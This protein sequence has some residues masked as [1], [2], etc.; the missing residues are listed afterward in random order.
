MATSYA[1]DL[2]GKVLTQT[3]STT[4]IVAG[5]WYTMTNN[6]YFLSDDSGGSLTTNTRAALNWASDVADMMVKFEKADDGY[7]IHTVN[8]KEGLILTQDNDRMFCRL[9]KNNSLFG[10]YWT[11]EKSGNGGRRQSRGGG[12]R[13]E[14]HPQP[15]GRQG[16]HFP[17]PG[18][19]FRTERNG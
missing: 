9:E 13:C 6:G 11:M 19:R 18:K 4:D 12:G 10:Q 14:L 7:Y 5:Q 16:C 8:G 2:T 3:K 17:A 1:N 15:C